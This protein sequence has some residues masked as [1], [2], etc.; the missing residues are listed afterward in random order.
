[1]DNE[2]KSDAI[3]VAAYYI[4]QKGY[5]YEELCWKLAVKE[6]IPEKAL[7]VF[8]EDASEDA[9]K[10]FHTWISQCIDVGGANLPKT[11]ST[12]LGSKLGKIYKS[13]GVDTIEQA[14]V[15]SYEVLKGKTEIIKKDEKTIEVKTEYLREFC[16]IGGHYAPKKA[17]LIQKSICT[18]FTI[19]FLSEID[20]R[21]KFEGEINE[22]ILTSNKRICFYTL[23]LEEKENNK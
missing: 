11:I 5:S 20:T 7:E 15:K 6:L 21:F 23:H 14:L 10:F 4:A 1:M 22:C 18:P 19:G 2:K 16:P 3:N 13:M 8:T 12:L 17:Q 9:L